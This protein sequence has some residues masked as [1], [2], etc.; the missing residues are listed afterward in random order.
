[1]IEDLFDILWLP[2]TDRVKEDFM[3]VFNSSDKN[4]YKEALQELIDRGYV[5]TKVIGIQE[6]YRIIRKMD[7]KTN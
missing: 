6:Y 2:I 7:T 5:E 4:M 3:S 1:M